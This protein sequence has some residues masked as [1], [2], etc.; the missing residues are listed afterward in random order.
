MKCLLYVN[1]CGWQRPFLDWV[2]GNV[3]ELVECHHSEEF[4]IHL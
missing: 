4:D 2:N 3:G 1:M